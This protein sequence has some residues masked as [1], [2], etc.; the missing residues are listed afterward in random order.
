MFLRVFVSHFASLVKPDQVSGLYEGF[1]K[2]KQTKEKIFE[3]EML[4]LSY[5]H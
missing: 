1:K 5:Q 3:E 4:S 2:K